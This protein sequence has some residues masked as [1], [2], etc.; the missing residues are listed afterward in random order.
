M[1]AGHR[2]GIVTAQ[3]AV[4]SAVS[5]RKGAINPTPKTR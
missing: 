5:Y 2:N 3:T 4:A 1:L